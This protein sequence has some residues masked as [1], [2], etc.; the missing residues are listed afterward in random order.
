MERDEIRNLEKQIDKINDRKYMQVYLF[1]LFGVFI[2]GLIVNTV[3]LNNNVSKL[4]IKI[5]VLETSLVVNDLIP[6]ELVK[7]K[8]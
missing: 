7:E 4:K 2:L 3:D 6:A 5:A 1:F 8:K